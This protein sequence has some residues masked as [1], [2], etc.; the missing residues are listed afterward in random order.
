MRRLA[1]V[2]AASAATRLLIGLVS[3]TGALIGVLSAPV[4][5]SPDVPPDVTISPTPPSPPGVPSGPSAAPP[6]EF[7]DGLADLIEGLEGGGAPGELTDALR[8]LNTTAGC[9]PV[10]PPGSGGGGDDPL[11][12]VKD[13][14]CP[15][16]DDLID[17]A[18][19]TPLPGEVIGG[20]E[21]IRADVVGCPTAPTP[22]TTT[23]TT[24]TTTTTTKPAV[25]PSGGG[26]VLGASVGA[27]SSGGALPR[28]GGGSLANL[29]IAM[30]GAGIL[31]RRILGA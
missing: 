28:T 12:P 18:R 30:A 10:P 22:T 4:H 21:T 29:A 31:G 17:A 8:D 7:C 23:T 2:I 15:V 26:G 19:G 5:A 6:T 27:G 9:P 1:A 24:P 13:A 20:L 16:L 3:L 11:A 25:P 14:V